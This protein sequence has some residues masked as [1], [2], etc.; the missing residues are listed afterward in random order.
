MMMIQV[1]VFSCNNRRLILSRK[2]L[3]YP[4]NCQLSTLCIDDTSLVTQSL[5]ILKFVRGLD[6]NSQEIILPV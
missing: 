1:G 2:K 4:T 5:I 6:E 3:K